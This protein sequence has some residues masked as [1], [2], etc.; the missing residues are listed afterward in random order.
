MLMT[1]LIGVGN[2]ALA[3]LVAA[4]ISL[5]TN[6]TLIAKASS[7]SKYAL[8]TAIVLLGFSMNANNLL[9][10]SVDYAAIVSLYVVVTL[11][12]GLFVGWLIKQESVDSKLIST[13]TAICGGTAI[14]SLSPILRASPGQTGM[15]LALV[16]VLNA[17]ALLSFPYA[18]HWLEL[19]QTQFG[20]WTALAIHDTSSVVATA[21]IYGEE[22]AQVA[23]TLKLGRTLW[24]VP[25]LLVFSMIEGSKDEKKQFVTV[26]N[27]IF[28]FV[29][30]SII[31]SYAN[32]P[33]ALIETSSIVSKALLVAALF[34]VGI[35]TT[36][37]NLKQLNQKHLLQGLTI[38]II[39][40]IAT[41]GFVVNKI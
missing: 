23:T 27:F 31:A 28:L 14:A 19:T 35:A 6:R 20:V 15:T 41:L 29:G 17:V 36:R 30:A 4:A 24:L 39:V 21:A 38:W 40:V 12:F 3:F 10:L 1:F 8:Q 5:W 18:G 34:L 25:V 22:A 33:A 16:F 37:E 7:Y 32:L 9:A 26:P 13:G 2:P 11:L